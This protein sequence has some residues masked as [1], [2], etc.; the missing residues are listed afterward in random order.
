MNRTSCTTFLSN[1]AMVSCMS[2]TVLI[3]NKDTVSVTA[4]SKPS[5]TP[6]LIRYSNDKPRA[7]SWAL[8]VFCSFIPVAESVTEF[9]VE[10]VA[11]HPVLE[12][13]YV[14][15]EFARRFDFAE[16]GANAGREVRSCRFGIARL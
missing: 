14:D 12:R 8:A 5:T 10:I 11:E 3:W 13:G 2:F 6:S 7:P 1:N 4:S 15:R 16:D 9:K